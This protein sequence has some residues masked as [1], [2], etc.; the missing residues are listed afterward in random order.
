MGP[1][2][3][4][5]ASAILAFGIASA[6]ASNGVSSDTIAKSAPRPP[7]ERRNFVACP[8]VRDTQ[9]VPCWLAEYKGELYYL[10][11][12]N[13]ISAPFH[14]PQLKHRALVE[15]VVANGP[16][17]CGGIPLKPAAVSVL[18][19]LDPSC[20]KILPAQG[21]RV[22]NPPRGPGP[23]NKGMQLATDPN[24]PPVAPPAPPPA[25]PYG[26]RELDVRYG[27]DSNYINVLN[28]R[29]VLD[30][31]AYAKASGAH[32]VRVEGHR[33]AT[34]LSNGRTLVEKGGLAQ[35]RADK[36]GQ[37]LR[38]LG[39]PATTLQVAASETLEASDGASDFERRRV[40]ILVTP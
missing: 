19:E 35:A 17:I 30:A 23:G 12:Q 15:A 33:A 38:E 6:L 2:A 26:S 31:A 3:R 34:L 4:T 8:V 14:P 20:N 13:D 32:E 36:V 29:A 9:E 1:S 22:D 10:G 5:I 25:P 18:P 40:R 37:A 7:P 11:I 28:F 39:V 16:R 24:P 21:Y 27:F